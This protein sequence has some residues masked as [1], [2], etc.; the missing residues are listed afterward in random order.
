MQLVT[1]LHPVRIFNDRTKSFEYV[2]CGKCDMCRNSRASKW[3]MRLDQE[4]KCWPYVVFFTLT[5]DN[6]Y[7]PTLRLGD[8]YSLCDIETGLY[9]DSETVLSLTS[10]ERTQIRKHKGVRYCNF[11]DVQLFMKRLRYH[12]THICKSTIDE[13]G[14]KQESENPILRYYIC[15][16]I[17]PTGLRPH[18]HGILYFS[19]RRC[20]AQIEDLIYKSWK[21]GITDTST[22]QSSASSYV[23]RYVNCAGRLPKIYQHRQLRPK[24]VFSKCP[25]IGSLIAREEKV[26]EIW[27]RGIPEI[28]V[29]KNQEYISIPLPA[30]LKNRLFPTIRNFDGFNHTQRVGLYSVYK[31][32]NAE[33][34]E[35]FREW[36]CTDKSVQ[37]TQL[38]KESIPNILNGLFDSEFSKDP[39]H[40]LRSL[41]RISK[42]VCTQAA[43]WNVSVNTYVEKIEQYRYNVEQRKLKHQ[44]ELQQEMVS[45][46]GHCCFFIHSDELF[47]SRLNNSS[48][49]DIDIGDRNI[50]ESYGI[51]V[52]R[53]F[54]DNG[55]RSSFDI[56]RYPEYVDY[57]NKVY[58]IC[59]DSHKTKA[60][61]E[62]LRSHPECRIV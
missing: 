25:P 3:V 21:L 43:A 55:Y 34:F 45:M 14:K 9:I 26:R 1:C 58:K 54:T 37:E 57:V 49:Y 62:W 50:L 19:S 35:E 5:Y 15:S 53:F 32:S 17:S 46:Y 29:A 61:K 39:L 36:L 33:T 52:F 24:A 8:D 4:A 22:V 38:I 47:I 13:N 30:F 44:Y 23:A 31:L 11:C 7:V 40:I 18:Y 60:R 16:E 2:P 10:M 59:N 48:L 51:D 6:R 27:E 41:Y 56:S 20:F 42:R 12:F 28:R